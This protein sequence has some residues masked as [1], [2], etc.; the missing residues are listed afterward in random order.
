[1]RFMQPT[2]RVEHAPWIETADYKAVFSILLLNVIEFSILLLNV[3]QL[4][5]EA[6]STYTFHLVCTS[7]QQLCN[8][9]TCLLLA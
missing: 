7:P 2:A 6:A 5:I 4:H 9:N 1:M 8:H 3:I